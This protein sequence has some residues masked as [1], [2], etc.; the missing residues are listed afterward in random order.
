MRG[1]SFDP[2]NAAGTTIGVARATVSS[3]WL[4]A[5]MAGVATIEL[6]TWQQEMLDDLVAGHLDVVLGD[7]LGYH[8]WLKSPDGAGSSSPAMAFASMRNW[9]RGPQG[10][11]RRCART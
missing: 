5:N 10:K 1:P 8:A 2:A 7:G 3:D 6:Y 9:H 4:E 11:T